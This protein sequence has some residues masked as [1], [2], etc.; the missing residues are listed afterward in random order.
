[1]PPVHTVGVSCAGMRRF[2]LASLQNFNPKSILDLGCGIGAYGWMIR[3]Y[4]K[5]DTWL[6]GADGYFPYLT[7][8]YPRLYNVLVKADVFDFVEGR[9]SIP[10]ECVMCM[11]VIEHFES[12]K[13]KRL[14]DWLLGQKLAYLSTPLFWFEQD[15]QHGNEL[16]KHR[17]GFS[18]EEVV[19]MGWKPIAKVRWDER[20][21]IGGFKNV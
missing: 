1:M 17:T 14:S 12:D 3:R 10:T 21:W 15:A 20:G 4:L 13:A 6:V 9:V 5:A 8:E 16:E 7:T 11:D 18:F 19:G 2:I